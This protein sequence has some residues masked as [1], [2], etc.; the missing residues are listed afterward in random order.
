MRRSALVLIAGF[1]AANCSSGSVRDDAKF[2]YENIY[3]DRYKRGNGGIIPITIERGESYSG[4]ITRDQRYLYFSSNNSGN[5]DIYLRDLTDV[6]SVP[7]VDTVTNQKEPSVSPDGKHIVYVDDELDP[8]GDIILLKV[9]PQKLIELYRERKEPDEGWFASRAKNLTNSEKNRI[10]ARDVNPTWSPDGNWIAY[11]SDLD[12]QKVDDLG[13]GAGAIQNIWLMPLGDPEK[14]QRLTTKGGVMPSFSHDGKKIVYISYQ[15]ENSLGAVYEVDIASG[16]T[17]RL[18]SGKQFDFYPTYAP[19]DDGIVLTRIAADTNGDG[20]IDRKDAGQIIRIYPEDD[21]TGTDTSYV[22][23][24]SKDGLVPTAGTDTSYVADDDF[25]PLSSQS[26]HVFD[27]RVSNFIGGSVVFAQLK[28][29]DINVA[30]IPISGAVPIKPDI[31]QQQSYLEGFRKPGKTTGRYCMGLQQ[32]PSAFHK[33]PDLAVYEALSYMRRARCDKKQAQ[34]FNEYLASADADELALYRLLADLSEISPEYADLKALAELEPLA[35]KTDPGKYFEEIL[36]DKKIWKYYREGQEPQDYL[37]ILS[38]IRHQQT[39]YFLRAGKIKEARETLKRILRENP[40]YLAVD[41]LLYEIGQADSAQ[42]PAAELIFLSHELPELGDLKAYFGAEKPVAISVRPNIRR[43]AQKFLLAFFERQFTAN[44]E[45]AVSDYLRGYPEKRY[46]TL[47]ALYYLAEARDHAH[48]ELYAESDAAAAKAIGLSVPGSVYNFYADIVRG[49]N[50]E[51]KVGRDA[52]MAIYAEAI[53]NYR[54]EEQPENVKEIVDKIG[55]YYKERA[56][57]QRA[58]G[59]DRA[60]AVEYEALLDLYLSAH[61]N[62]LTKELSSGDLLDFALNLDQVALRAR[63]NDE[64]LLT[65]ILK[66]YDARIDLARRYLVTE[67]IF[68]RGFL[69]AQLGISRHIAAEA[70]GLTK[71]EKKQVFEDFRKAEVDLN[72]C[73]FAN[74]KFADA[75][76][77]LGWMYQFI[78]EKREVV[79]EPSSGKRDREVFEALYKTYFPDYL[80]EKN[81]RL[82]QKTLALFGTSGSARVRNSFHLNI[83][84]NYFLL[85]NYSQAEEHYTAILDKKGNP[86]Y[87]FESPEQEFMFYYHLGRTLYFTGKNDAAIRYLEYVENN[88]NSRYPLQGLSAEKLKINQ[89]RRETAYK[90]FAL[91]SEYSQNLAKAISY[92]QAIIGERQ[93][94]GAESPVSMVFLELARLTLRQGDFNSSLDYTN[95]AEAAL[96]KEE[97]I[98]IPKFKIRIKWFWVYEPWTWLV[99]LIYKL[100]Y[101]DVYIGDNHLAF[102]LPTVNRYQLLYSIRA[103]IFRSKGL[104]QDASG[105]LAQLVEQAEKDDTKHGKETLSSAVSRRAELEFSLKNWDEA[106][107]L[108]ETAV[109]QA[110]KAGNPGAALTFRKNIELCRLRKLE[111]QNEGLAE[112]LKAARRNFE[113]VAEYEQKIINERTDAAVA[114]LK[115]QRKIDEKPEPSK[116]EIDKIQAEINKNVKAELQP[117]LFFKGLNLAHEAELADF[118]EQLQTKPESF[119]Q[120][121]AHK[122]VAFD[123]HAGA[124]KFFRGYT[125]EYFG[126]VYPEFEPDLKNNSLRLKLAMNRAKVLQE[127]NLF[128]E[129]VAEFREIQEKSQEFRANLEYAISTYRAYRVYEDAETDDKVNIAP[130]RAL[131]TYFTQNQG[132][133]RANTDLFERLCNILTDRALRTGNYADALRFEDLKRQSTGLQMYFDDLRLY[134][135]K[136]EIFQKLLVT[137]QKRAGIDSRIRLARLSK[138]PQPQLEKDLADADREATTLRQRL[139]EPDRLDYRYETFFAEGYS[140]VEVMR[141][142]NRGILYVMRPRDETVVVLAKAE[143]QKKGKALRYE[144]FKLDP[145]KDPGA[146]LADIAKKS[147][148]DLVILSPQVLLPALANE[149]IRKLSLQTSLRAA[150]NFTNNPDRARR[151][152]LQIV[153]SASFFSFGGSNDVNYGTPQPIERVRTGVEVAN[154]PQHRNVVDYEGELGRKTVLVDNA[155][156][157]PAALFNMRANPNYAI[158][159]RT[160]RDKLLPADDFRF[161]AAADLYFSAM[162]AGQV[163]HTFN[164][165]GSAKGAIAGFLTEGSAAPGMLLTGNATLSIAKDNPA[166]AE[167]FAAQK[168]SYAKKIAAARKLGEYKEAASYA[169]DALSLFPQDFDFHAAAAELYYRQGE[170]AQGAA[171]FKAAQPDKSLANRKMQA[172]LLL[173]SGDVDGFRNYLAAN[174]DLRAD[175]ARESTEF[176]GLMQLAAFMRGETVLLAGPMP[177]ED[178]QKT[179]RPAKRTDFTHALSKDLKNEELRN[180]IC[181]AAIGALEYRL[182]NDSCLT[183]PGIQPADRAERERVRDLFF[184]AKPGALKA[185]DADDLEFIRSVAL[186]KSGFAA[187]ALASAKKFLLRLRLNTSENLLTLA[188]LH[189]LAERK[190]NTTD[191][192]AIA[193]LLTDY[194][195]E[196]KKKA[197]NKQT[198]SYYHLLGLT[199][200]TFDKGEET[201]SGFAATGSTSGAISAENNI[202][203]LGISVLPATNSKAFVESSGL[204]RDRALETDLKFFGETASGYPEEVDCSAHNCAPLIKRHLARGENDAALFLMLHRQKSIASRKSVA[205]LPAG[206]FG[207]GEVFNDEI[208]EWFFDGKNARFQKLSAFDEKSVGRIKS[209]EKYLLHAAEHNL[210]SRAKLAPP[211]EAVLIEGPVHTSEDQKPSVHVTI[212]AGDQNALYSVLLVSWGKGK[213]AQDSTGVHVKAPFNPSPAESGAHAIYIYTDRLPLDAARRLK[214][215][216]YHLFCESAESYNGFVNFA[217]KVVENMIQAKMPVE[218]AYESAFKSLKGKQAATRPLYYLYRN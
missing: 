161:A 10:R 63:S 130:Y 121:L 4:T 217:Q 196:A 72:W 23:A 64:E 88:L 162:G 109:K 44:Q 153:K 157:T 135:A 152:V 81:I 139:A 158:V 104:L 79:V 203:M 129:S 147:G 113:V 51:I 11:S 25:V 181:N 208:Y 141:L 210:F 209:G 103:E 93:M 55:V 218:V 62:K 132:F 166:A 131:V 182:V 183:A 171:H 82:Y 128:D 165:R 46:K 188:F 2:S 66:F 184:A 48:E 96:A 191:S 200:D 39:L 189:V 67:F 106:L 5:Y 167:V 205:A 86:D 59:N 195:R 174:A 151:N 117:L 172:R 179:K 83:A 137:E 20:Q 1:F 90:T 101:D 65:G 190:A 202:R 32:L 138:T 112:K 89:T 154:I 145:A 146:E 43:K 214:P 187:D 194:G 110:E 164:S 18:T 95:K 17:R 87:Q 216:G 126:D 84:N 34:E 60:A 45:E 213:K 159:S 206:T 142:A 94:V 68:G 16:K 35:E 114:A 136:D 71:S 160:S 127:M 197:R 50:A 19:A 53:R 144:S 8:D 108:F 143:I 38:F 30:F 40:A 193:K 91:N 163:L 177:W 7:V 185:I 123:R 37:A 175:L 29:D 28:G 9:N 192:R 22:A 13:A 149:N 207:Y 47:N 169:E 120:F 134:G 76:V 33:S 78:D 122:R 26:D 204:P 118:S 27:T 80:F 57:Q 77:M 111:T 199:A 75:Y 107:K 170:V 42:L 124:L 99:G 24:G 41:E 54:D 73:F 52:S 3:E 12:P 100:P 180:E 176:E 155:F 125:K 92:N 97:K 56:D 105:A 119:D 85:N 36:R 212:S 173:R 211:R 186:L 15:D 74:A 102:D 168:I 116:E 140:E 31:R 150:L 69:R 61:A 115:K 98:P 58:G 148:A 198:E 21:T 49:G 156:L 133:L 178:G 215:R 201:L 14:K 6:F 70:D